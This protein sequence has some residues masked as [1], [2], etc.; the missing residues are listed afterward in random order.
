[1]IGANRL[2]STWQ[3][4]SQAT[5]LNQL[6]GNDPPPGA[7]SEL[8]R[9]LWTDPR[10]LIYPRKRMIV[11]FSPKSA[12]T[13]VVI[14]FFHQ[15][16]H[17]AA[18]RDYSSWPHR[19]RTEVYYKSTLYRHA[20]ERDLS[21]FSLVRIVRDP[22]ERAVSSFRHV[23]KG[24]L[25]DKEITRALGR[26]DMST[27]GL[28]FSEFLDFLERCDLNT[29]DPH[30][31]VQRH[32][33]EDR[34]P[35][36]HLINASTEDLFSR[37]N[38]VEADF[39]LPIT[40]FGKLEWLQKINSKHRHVE[41]PAAPADAYNHRFNREAAR[42]GSWPPYSAFLTADARERLARL[43]ARDIEAYG[44]AAATHKQRGKLALVGDTHL[45]SSP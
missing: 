1:M 7:A 42:N 33:L 36:R 26:N 40:E 10:P 38:E 37:L 27:A 19:Y 32:P 17:T 35:T 23:Q 41:A 3:A 9:L 2:R 43:Y 12:C 15:L 16:G 24:G 31:R 22:F 13:S 44:G 29:C 14:W 21:K 6:T 34:L 39:N 5:G 4:L 45:D 8:G 20:Y 18:A 30:F 25:A 28:S 11:V